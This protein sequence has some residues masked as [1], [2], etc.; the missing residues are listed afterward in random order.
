MAT[1]KETPVVT[2]E[3]PAIDAQRVL[4]ELD[5]LDALMRHLK[6]VRE[7]ALKIGKALIRDG[8]FEMGRMLI[9]LENQS[10]KVFF[11]FLTFILQL[12][13]IVGIFALLG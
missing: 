5:K 1:T 12:S 2:D 11:A 6:N 4:N 10:N 9:A 8:E 7:A 3:K 13:Y